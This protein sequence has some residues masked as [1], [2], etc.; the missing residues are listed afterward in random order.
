MMRSHWK[1]DFHWLLRHYTT[2]K[3]WS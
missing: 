3:R 1:A 2:H